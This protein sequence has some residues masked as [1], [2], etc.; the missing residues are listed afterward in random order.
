MFFYPYTIREEDPLSVAQL[1][2]LKKEMCLL[3]LKPRLN[4]RA[5]A[6]CLYP[7]RLPG[8]QLLFGGGLAQQ[9]NSRCVLPY[10]RGSWPNAINR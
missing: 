10:R 1:N 4:Q 7:Y 5:A 9:Q 6:G 8:E 2:A 3:H